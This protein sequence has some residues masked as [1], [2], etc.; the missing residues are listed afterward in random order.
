MTMH[1]HHPLFHLKAIEKRHANADPELIS[2]LTEASGRP[3]TSNNTN[4]EIGRL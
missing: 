2:L 4:E 1:S 3:M